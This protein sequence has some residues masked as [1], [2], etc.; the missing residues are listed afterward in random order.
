MPKAPKS[1]S[2]SKVCEDPKEYIYKGTK[3]YVWCRLCEKYISSNSF[4]R[5]VLRKHVP[6]TYNC[7]MCPKKFSSQ[8]D[9]NSHQSFHSPEK[10]FECLRCG[11]KFKW[12]SA[13]SNHVKKKHPEVPRPEALVQLEWN[14]ED[15]VHAQPSLRETSKIVYATDEHRTLTGIVRGRTSMLL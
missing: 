11:E 12:Q 9:L 1:K 10:R 4:N 14:P 15:F 13:R 7:A 6:K 3:R 8:V 5:H 2:K